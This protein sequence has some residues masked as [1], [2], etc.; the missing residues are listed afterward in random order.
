MLHVVNQV[1]LNHRNREIIC[2]CYLIQIAVVHKKSHPPSFFLTNSTELEYGLLLGLIIP[3]CIISTASLSLHFVN[4][5]IYRV[6]HIQ[7][8]VP[9]SSKFDD[10]L[11]FLE[12]AFWVVQRYL[13][14]V[15]VEL[16]SLAVLHLPSL[17]HSAVVKA[18]SP[19]RII[20]LFPI[21]NAMDFIGQ[22]TP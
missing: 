8:S 11:L 15:L 18:G 19:L 10:I 14:I 1:I 20:G 21:I 5:H 3:A 4:N 6:P 17:E 9:P 7:A 13:H 16:G 2:H 12:V 22:C